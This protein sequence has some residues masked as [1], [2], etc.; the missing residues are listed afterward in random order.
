M[1]LDT[2]RH[3]V[4]IAADA[5]IPFNYRDARELELRSAWAYSTS[6][7]CPMRLY[8]GREEKHFVLSTQPTAK[9]ATE[10]GLNVQAIAVDGGH[11]SA[12]GAEIKMAIDFFHHAQ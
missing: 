1:L 2:T 10:H 9:L 7:K 6:F 5:D 4:A 3:A 8:Y 12:E 11:N